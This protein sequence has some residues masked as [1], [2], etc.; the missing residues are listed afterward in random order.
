MRVDPWY[1]YLALP[2]APSI[3][4]AQGFALL[5][6]QRAVRWVFSLAATA[7]IAAMF[8]YVATLPLSAD[9]GANIGAGVLFLW[10]L[11]S[12]GLLAVGVVRDRARPTG[13]GGE[14][15]AA[16]GSRWAKTAIG[17]SLV[18]LLFPAL[19][20]LVVPLGALALSWLREPP[21]RIRVVATGLTALTLAYVVVVN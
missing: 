11:V 12:L 15:G 19:F 1:D 10:L 21:S 14:H 5:V 13:P 2:I 8:V 18:L 20:L 7:A 9:E 16:E 17:S 6:P 4:M 3:L